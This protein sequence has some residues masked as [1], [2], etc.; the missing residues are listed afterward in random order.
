MLQMKTLACVWMLLAAAAAQTIPK[1][2]DPITGQKTSQATDPVILSAHETQTAPVTYPV[3]DVNKARPAATAINTFGIKMLTDMAAQHQHQNVFISPLSIFA[4]LV[5]TENGA[6]G[7]TRDAMRKTLAIP[8]SLSEA[9][10]HGSA[11]TL[12][13][14]L[15]S[16]KGAELAI[17]NALWSDIKVPLSPDFIQ[18]CRKLYEAEAT[19]LD[20]SKP[21]AANT[22]NNWVKEKTRNKIP[23]IVTPEIV[24]ASEAIL[25]NAVYFHGK[26][27]TQFPKAETQEG[28]FHLANGG[29]KKVPLMHH[30]SIGNA[31]RSGDGYE[32]AA[33]PYEASGIQMYAILPAAGK[34][35]EEILGRISVEKLRSPA[36]SNELDLKLPRFNLDFS[37]GLKGPLNQL[38]MGLAFQP[39]G[40]FAPL[41]SPKFYVGDVLH[42]TRLE[43]DEEGTV[44]AAATGVAMLASAVHAQPEKKVLVFDRPFALLLCDV[45]TGAILFAGVVY[46]PK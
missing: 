13:K 28:I 6:S 18:R 19:T 45:Q 5:M 35:P 7:Q 29:Q 27:Q 10:L 31:Y 36:R 12:L 2:A 37:A 8:D 17:A 1:P 11:S 43:V 20:F 34:S 32:A 41:G 23:S 30:S 15:Q 39:R 33:L 46:E 14:L 26:W 44:A 24:R 22:I 4:A 21:A 3:A 38:G 40:D 9:G 42:K 25:T 16:Q